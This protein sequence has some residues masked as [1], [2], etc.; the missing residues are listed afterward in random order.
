MISHYCETQINYLNGAEIQPVSVTVSNARDADTTWEHEG[1]QRLDHRSAVKSWRDADEVAACYYTEMAA[2]A[3]RLT[4]CDQAIVVGHILRDPGQ[5]ELHEDYA[6]IQFAHSD[7]AET[8][9]DALRNRYAEGRESEREALERA[10]A[11]I[12]DVVNATDLMVLQFW[13]NV[14]PT[15]MDLPLAFCDA[16]STTRD[17]MLAFNVPSYAGTA[18]PFDT[19]GMHSAAASK[20]RWSVFPALQ[21]S[22]V[23]TFRTFDSRRVGTDQPF[24]TPHSAFADPVVANPQ[25]RASIE[26]RAT[27]LFR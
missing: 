4:G 7:F 18:D 10:G 27:C 8:Y 25:P 26:V 6:P 17:D 9:G 5:A 1:Y 21:D 22:E 16:T 3:Q 20:H 12:D 15:D 19:L 23:I 2:V 11:S 14:G 24:W 13:R